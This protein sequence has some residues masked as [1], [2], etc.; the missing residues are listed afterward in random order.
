MGIIQLQLL[1]GLLLLRL[2]SDGVCDLQDAF[3]LLGHLCQLIHTTCYRAQDFVT[4]VQVFLVGVAIVRL[5][6]NGADE[7]RIALQTGHGKNEKMAKGEFAAFSLLLRLV[8]KVTEQHVGRCFFLDSMFC[9]DNVRAVS[10]IN[11]HESMDIAQE[12]ITNLVDETTR[13]GR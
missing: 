12:D 5:L 7:Q 2:V 9:K 4:L 8:D 10:G 13:G 6:Q 3:L 1:I 11:V